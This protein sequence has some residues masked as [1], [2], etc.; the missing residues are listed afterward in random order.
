MLFF[1][2]TWYNP[3]FFRYA[4]LIRRDIVP[5]IISPA[6]PPYRALHAFGWPV[7]WLRPNREN[8]IKSS[9]AHATR[10]E[11]RKRREAIV[12]RRIGFRHRR[13]SRGINRGEEG[14]VEGVER[15]R[16]LHRTIAFRE[17]QARGGHDGIISSRGRRTSRRTL[18]SRTRGRVEVPEDSL[19][20]LFSA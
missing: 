7:D 13:K 12:I 8:F 3:Y 6:V 17:S 9:T 16:P 2:Y 20:Q 19:P 18:G 4:R 11:F 15:K 1:Q 10:P 5:D 14:R